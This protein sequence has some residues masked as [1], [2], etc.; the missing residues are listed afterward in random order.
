MPAKRHDNN[1]L[2]V[3]DSFHGSQMITT[4]CA[5]TLLLFASHVLNSTIFPQVAQTFPLAREIS[6]YCG[7]IFSILVAV[8]AYCRPSIL[9]ETAWSTG[10]LIIFG[11][12]ITMLTV[13]VLT[14]NQLIVALGSPF[15]GI[16]GIWFSVLVGLALIR[17]QPLRALT[18]IPTAYIVNFALQF[19]GNQ[20]LPTLP[21]AANGVLYFTCIAASYILI[22]SD[23]HEFLAHIRLNVAPRVLD[24]TNPAAFLPFSSPVFILVALFNAACGFTLASQAMPIANNS[25]M[26]SFIPV[27]FVFLI[28][29]TARTSFSSDRLYHVAALLVFAG[30]LVASITLAGAHLPHLVDI[31]QALLLGGVNCFGILTYYVISAVGSRNLSGA[32]LTSALITAA[33]WL[34]MGIGSAVGYLMK[35]F[36]AHSYD[37]AL[38]IM[39]AILFAFMAY[40]FIGTHNFSFQNTIQEVQPLPIAAHPA[41]SDQR[42]LSQ[43][44]LHEPADTTSDHTQQQLAEACASLA[45]TY[46]LT[47]RECDVLALLARG[48]TSAVI[49]EKLVLSRNTV[50]T[51]VRHV[52][53]KMD[54]HSQ[55]E[56]I[57]L[58]EKASH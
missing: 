27:F 53:S 8:F 31:S 16:G 15:G 51:H 28:V 10:C 17:L 11:I 49:Q 20:I 13:G 50:K 29:I 5:L 44:S 7:V 9:R 24:V 32:F 35:V 25:V 23:I 2:E 38:I 42:L 22:R 21:L 33:D 47:P 55:Q 34:G 30:L 54:I 3:N 43:D 36:G 39:A 26:L 40:N 46:A 6:T 45:Q 48:R 37:A 1:S 12:S 4:C 56:L 58:V 52:Y 19:A 41:D 57:D 18:I 14:Q